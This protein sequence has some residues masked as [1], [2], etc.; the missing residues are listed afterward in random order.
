MIVWISVLCIHQKSLFSTI[1]L[2]CIAL[3]IKQARASRQKRIKGTSAQ[4]KTNANPSNIHTLNDSKRLT[5]F[6]SRC[7]KKTTNDESIP[8]ASLWVY[9]RVTILRPFPVHAIPDLH[10]DDDVVMLCTSRLHPVFRLTVVVQ[11]KICSLEMSLLQCN[12]YTL[13]SA[14]K[15]RVLFIVGASPG[16]SHRTCQTVHH[17]DGDTYIIKI[18]TLLCMYA[19]T[20][21]R[22]QSSTELI[23][24]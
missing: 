3:R 18:S 19:T 5:L 16:F 2:H 6:S 22:S 11:L 8:R 1:A 14:R 23:K 7:N 20:V 21:G 17:P 4:N 10:P 24:G 9:R 15:T 12:H 13:Y